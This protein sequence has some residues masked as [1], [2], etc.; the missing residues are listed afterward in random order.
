MSFWPKDINNLY[1]Y[2]TRYSL[3]N[4]YKEGL[5]FQKIQRATGVPVATRHNYLTPP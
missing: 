3:R 1:V 5:S 2:T 4:H